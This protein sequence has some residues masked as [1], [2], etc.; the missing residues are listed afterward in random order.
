MSGATVMLV[1]IQNEAG[2]N[3]KNYHDEKTL[4]WRSVAT[5]SRKYP[6]PYGFVVGTDSADGC[7]LDCFVITRRELKSGQLVDCR[8]V[9]LME[10]FED[11]Q[12]DHNVLAMLTDEDI[13]V[14]RD[15][16]LELTEFVN[17][18]FEHVEGKRIRVGR[19][20]GESAAT[21]HIEAYRERRF[22]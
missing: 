20:L 4:E 1:F 16:E 6:F 3:Q 15:I 11:G 14:D 18:V 9:G 19:F 7:N 5:V 2:S 22:G 21:A 13:C 12:N 17:H 8:P 10:Q